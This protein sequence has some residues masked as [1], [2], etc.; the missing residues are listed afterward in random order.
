MR[1][2][3]NCDR[4]VVFGVFALCVDLN[5]S[6]LSLCTRLQQ[7]ANGYFYVFGV[8][9]SS[10]ASGR[11][12]GPNWK[13]AEVENSREHKMAVS[14]RELLVSQLTH[15]IAKKNF[16]LG[17]LNIN[18]ERVLVLVFQSWDSNYLK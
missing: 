18:R 3:N 12:V 6:Y 4:F 13:K 11:D 10:D 2:L 17:L 16:Q 9:L 1:E 15:K 8:H 14:K 5:Y 7:N